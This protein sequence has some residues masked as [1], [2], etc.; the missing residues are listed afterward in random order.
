MTAAA[1]PTA[2]EAASAL[3]GLL[4]RADMSGRWPV[5]RDGGW[6]RLGDEYGLSVRDLVE[7][8]TVVGRHAVPLPLTATLALRPAVPEASPA[9][10]T[11]AVPRRFR[12]DRVRIPFGD[13]P[14]I[15]VVGL[16]GELPPDAVVDDFAPTLRVVRVCLAS[17]RPVGAESGRRLAVLWAAEAVGAARVLVERAVEHARTRV[18]FGRPIGALQAVKHLLADATVGVAE[19]TTALVMAAN[20]GEPAAGAVRLALAG[21]VRAGEISLQVFGG[22]G[23]T[24]ELGAHLRVR[25]VLMLRDLVEDLLTSMEET[26]C[27]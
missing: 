2:L 21:A 5:I 10:L 14:G 19:A 23:M 26:P 27:P 15:H 25:H 18:Q 4:A 16:A 17:H 20:D 22:I 13:L 11:V 9:P 7:V 6:D 3:S 8:A 12:P 1:S 24:W